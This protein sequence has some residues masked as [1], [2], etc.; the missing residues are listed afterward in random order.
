ML[1]ISKNFVFGSFGVF[2][3]Q[4]WKK[5]LSFEKNLL[6]FGK[7]PEFSLKIHENFKSFDMIFYI[8]RS[9]LLNNELLVKNLL[10]KI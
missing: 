10:E 4:F 5:F 9:K 7:I 2:R 3:A 1:K 6:S 8:S